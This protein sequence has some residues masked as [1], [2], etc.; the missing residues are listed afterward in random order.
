MVHVRARVV[1][2]QGLE[3]IASRDALRDLAH[4]GAIEHLAQLGL[5]DQDD[6]QQLL[7]RRL[8]VRQEAHLLEQL[9]GQRLR[10]ID[11]EH[12]PAAFGMRVHELHVQRVDLRLDRPLDGRRAAQLLDDRFEELERRELWAE[13]QRDVGFLGQPLEHAADQRRLAR[14][15]FARELDE[16]AA[17]RDAVEKMCERVGVPR[18]HIE[19]ARIR[20]DRER[21]L[22]EAEELGIHVR[23][24]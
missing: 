11:D 12:H 16:A 22:V 8:E 9:G 10:F 3:V 7:L 15:D 17:L 4:L 14:A 19:I 18:A 13:D 1:L 21:L 20:S 6:L 24:R 5:P 23:V 2:A